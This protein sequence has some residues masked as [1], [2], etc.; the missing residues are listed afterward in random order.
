MTRL[1]YIS[2]DGICEALG[3]S[4]ILP[5]LKILSDD[6]DIH[7]ISFEKPSDLN[8]S[9]RITTLRTNLEDAGLEWTPLRYHKRPSILATLYDIVIGQVIGLKIAKKIQADI[10]HVRSYIPA[11][12]ALPI[13]RFISAKILFDIRGFWADE[14]VDGGIW[15]S[16]GIIYRV[17]KRIER[18]LFHS[19]D[20]IITLT[21]ASVSKIKNFGY[22]SD[23][24]PKIT[25]IPTCADL[26]IFI[27]PE[28]T[29]DFDSFVF[30]YVGSFGTWYM[31]EET[32]ALFSAILEFRPEAR[33]IIVNHNEHELVRATIARVGLPIDR[34]KITQSS[35][36]KVPMH[37]KQMHAASALI[38][39][40][41]SKI[42]SAPTKLA[43][44]L[45]CAVPCVGSHQVGDMEKI[46]EGGETG[47]ILRSFDFDSL[48]QAA[49]RIISLSESADA[50]RRC[51]EIAI[52]RFSLKKGVEAYRSVYK[53]LIS[54]NVESGLTK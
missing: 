29:P 16:N 19:A 53:K 25:V 35:Y 3:Q 34:I 28:K 1:L 24:S 13:K 49:Q 36:K 47:V 30:G 48:K 26:D 42:A 37:I 32:M 7:I 22:W 10:I 23:I 45:G 40:S 8:N 44:Y 51:R 9:K 52:A 15:P 38:R 5:Y 2:Y 31:I 43:E 14:R 27:P 41:F 12:I 54:S 21:E 50:R 4:Q 6:F 39:P 20:H 11:M 46:L 17:V 18:K 33:M